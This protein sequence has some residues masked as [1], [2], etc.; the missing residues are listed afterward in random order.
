[1][2]LKFS[3][4]SIDFQSFTIGRERVDH[5]DPQL[6]LAI[7]H[8]TDHMSGRQNYLVTK[9]MAKVGG[10][11]VYTSMLRVCLKMLYR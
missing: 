1:M 2:R 3:V 6:A 11:K 4:I 5:R 10:P 7:S 9:D 8:I